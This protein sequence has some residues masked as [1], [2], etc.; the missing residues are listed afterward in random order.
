MVYQL[1]TFVKYPTT[2]YP[3]W[4]KGI[5]TFI[6]PFAFSGYFPSAYFLGKGSFVSGILLTILVA[7]GSILVAY[8]IWLIGMSRYESTGS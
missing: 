5:L 6:I 4:I 8:R 2:I 3:G 1:S 7:I